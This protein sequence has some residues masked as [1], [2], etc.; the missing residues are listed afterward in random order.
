MDPYYLTRF[1]NP[2]K[3]LKKCDLPGEK[4]EQIVDAAKYTL[5]DVLYSA[6]CE[7]AD[8]KVRSVDKEWDTNGK[9]LNFLDISNPGHPVV[10]I[11][12]VR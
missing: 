4:E 10:Q 6:P 12:G 5:M 7:Y 3:D 11:P 1:P 2:G 9:T 8:G